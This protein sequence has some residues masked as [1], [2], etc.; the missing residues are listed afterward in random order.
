M[1]F[2]QKLRLTIQ[3][4][5]LGLYLFLVVA[6]VRGATSLIPLDLFLRLD[7]LVALT[8]WMASRQVVWTLA[9]AGFTLLATF[10]LGRVWCGWLCPLGTSLDVF[11]PGAEKS[12]RPPAHA[13]RSVKHVLLLAIL[14]AALLGNL[15]LL[16]LDPITIL[17]RTL[18]VVIL[19]GLTWLVTVA[20]SAL[21]PIGPVQGILEGIERTF[22][23][24]LLAAQQPYYQ[25]NVLLALFLGAIMALNWI[26]PRFWCRYLCPLG[27]LLALVAKVAWLRP[28]AISDCSHCAQCAIACPTGTI[29][30]NKKGFD[31]DPAEC[32]VCLDCME[33][34]PEDV[35][36]IRL[37]RP[38]LDRRPYDPSR[39]H[40]LI[41]M[42]GAI[43]GVALLRT[44][45][46]ARR[47][48]DSAQDKSF[49]SAQDKSFDSA[50]DKDNA[51]LVRPPGAQG[52]DF[53]A[54]CIRCAECIKICPTNGLQ[55]S[56]FEAGLV[57][58][59]T[60][61]LVSRLG[62]CDY[63]CNACGSICPTGA[64]PL[65]SLEEKRLRVIGHAYIDQN[66]CLPWA[67]NIPCIVCE[68]MCPL[69]D[70]AVKLDEADVLDAQGQ[71]L[72]IKRPRVL[73]EV[74]I[75]CGICEY[76][77]PLNGPAAI[78]VYVPNPSIA[79]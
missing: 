27:G 46:A 3:W 42:A 67:D 71:P 59:W 19:P 65:L 78:R 4:L 77:C 7:P 40:A 11:S 58:F 48:F 25:L 52:N 17:N 47:S 38:V 29:T 75:G 61:I 14:A 16:V 26:A 49:D 13:W 50:Q 73:R 45:P 39:R 2:M 23:G 74:C 55:P 12:R 70:K 5:A 8:D 41:A 57:G 33:I 76:Q 35:I 51:W 60:P 72:H 18:A 15:T 68:E 31:V 54:K 66:R 20:E 56:L 1:A 37:A 64:I 62:P 28:V 30:V 24:N 79:S 34:C 32:T 21:Y 53:L 69:P 43:G 10:V 36:A 9:L 44:E 22:R 6:T 63:S